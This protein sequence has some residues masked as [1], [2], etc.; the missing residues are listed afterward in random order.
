MA[1]TVD[2]VEV[3]IVARRDT[4]SPALEK[5]LK[6]AARTGL[7]IDKLSRAAGM[8]RLPS[9]FSKEL[10]GASGAAAKL[11]TSLAG[12]R[13]N[14]SAA[15]GAST[16]ASN[17]SAAQT[18]ASALSRTLNTLR[19]AGAGGGRGGGPGGGGHGPGGG[20]P[21]G[22]G[23]FNRGFVHTMY[24]AGLI[25]HL[26]G[27]FFKP[28]IEFGTQ[29]AM[30]ETMGENAEQRRR[31]EEAAYAV[32]AKVPNKSAAELMKIQRELL[33]IAAAGAP[34]ADGALAK[35][36][37]HL[38]EAARMDTLLA[39]YLGEKPG[40]SERGHRMSQFYNALRAGELMG[41][42][43]DPLR[44]FVDEASKAMVAGGGRL[45][46]EQIR[47]FVATAG[48]AAIGMDPNFILKYLPELM[49]EQGGSKV[50]TMAS[51]FM[52]SGAGRMTKRAL[53]EN[54]RLGLIDP[55]KLEFEKGR[56]KRIGEGAWQNESDRYHNP[57]KWALE[58]LAPAL[59]KQGIDPF[60]RGNPRLVRELAMLFSD[61]NAQK[62]MEQLLLHKNAMQRFAERTD[63]ARLDY[64]RQRSTN[65]S[66]AL[67]GLAGSWSTLRAALGDNSMMTAIPIIN[68][69]ASA[70]GGLAKS[71][72]GHPEMAHAATGATLYLGGAAASLVALGAA[73]RGVIW[74]GGGLM[75]IARGAA[76]VAAAAAPAGAALAALAARLGPISAFLATM[77]P[78]TT[79][80][81]EKEAIDKARGS[82]FPNLPAGI[83][84]D[85]LSP[86]QAK[87]LL[88]TA[89]GLSDEMRTKL[90]E[91]SNLG[92]MPPG[93]D[94][95]IPGAA[96]G[97]QSSLWD[98]FSPISSAHAAEMPSLA[99]PGGGG[100]MAAA[101]AQFGQ[102]AVAQINGAIQAMAVT[103]NG[104]VNLAGDVHLTAP[105]LFEAVGR[106][107]AQGIAHAMGGALTSGPAREHL[108][109]GPALQPPT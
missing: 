60:S 67:E 76:A 49:I 52:Q 36:I 3:D 42:T 95:P 5:A 46:M 69:M 105:G 37:E 68:G 80:K 4:L 85:K 64:E 24:D 17:L 21:W 94:F 18:R 71:I 86:E 31:M 44:G 41:L 90:Q 72:A 43:G 22:H 28:S 84:V 33:P 63:R 40:F 77:S 100:D 57:A 9:A 47:Q 29:R 23:I 8:L 38:P 106:M 34:D 7:E 92:F 58:T 107:L 50:G 13:L 103:L 99:G 93:T 97:K 79:N 53:E 6:L 88:G 89:Y 82:L 1:V 78:S 26:A 15:S 55:S 19:M 2:L 98:R 96:L 14:P 39:N 62:F 74:A 104:Q 59:Q 87:Q 56:L 75:S 109:G 65:P 108:S 102:A 27:Q 101:G 25:G 16:L 32:A 10:T 12:V 48:S 51:T 61:R 35:M 81:G 11:R 20:G 73:A 30:A 70:M 83:G 45:N 54:M 66:I 91:R